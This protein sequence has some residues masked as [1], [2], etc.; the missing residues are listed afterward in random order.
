MERLSFAISGLAEYRTT[1][2]RGLVVDGVHAYNRLGFSPTAETVFA[3]SGAIPTKEI[4][5][6][7][8]GLP[9][10]LEIG[11]FRKTPLASFFL[12][13]I[14]NLAIN[15]PAEVCLLRT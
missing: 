14:N 2:L 8:R 4:A 10:G 12:H 9:S 15:R 11:L 13:N 6:P 1:R 5:F 7:F 3:T